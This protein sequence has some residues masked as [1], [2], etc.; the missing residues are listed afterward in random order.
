M[1]TD[2]VGKDGGKVFLLSQ[3]HLGLE[4]EVK[5]NR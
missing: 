5:E 3:Q 4:D 1:I 2:A